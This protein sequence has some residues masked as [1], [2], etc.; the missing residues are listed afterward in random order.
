[1][2][3]E[4]AVAYINDTTAFW[5]RYYASG[6][7][8]PVE[9]TNPIAAAALRWFGGLAGKRLLDIGF[10][11]GEFALLF[12]SL[13]AQVVAIE[14][15]DI[16]VEK[17]RRY[18]AERGIDNLR[19]MNLSAFDILGTD[20]FDLVFGSMVLHHLEPFA[21]FAAALGASLL[22][23]GRAF[24]YENNAGIGRLPIWFRQHL[25]GKLFFPKYGDAGEFP[26]T[27]AE[28]DMLRAHFAVGVEYPEF[29]YFRLLSLYVFRHRL[30]PG[31]FAFLDRQ[32][33]KV[34]RLRRSSYVQYLY[35][36]PRS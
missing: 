8:H 14:T 11:A 5:N 15:S 32:C 10:G 36:R 18:A 21:D 22:P 17:L 31:A 16:A 7:A 33:F 9:P 2:P 1:L 34:P 4:K 6:S 27:P 29:Q 13:G 35:L 28:V 23:G 12:A 20:T 26:L 25:A 19:V 3:E 30:F 24:F